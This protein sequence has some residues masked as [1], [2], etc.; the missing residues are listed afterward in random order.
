[1]KDNF[2]LK[3]NQ[4]EVFDELTDEEAGRLIKGIFSY[5]STGESNL[6]GSL[7]AVFIPIKNDIDRNEE[8]Y[9]RIVER[10]RENGK[11]GG[12]PKKDNDLEETQKNQSVILET[13]EN[14]KKPDTR[15]ISYITNHISNINNHNSNNNL[16]IIKEI[17]NYLNLK[18]N[19]SYKYT[20][21]ATQQKINARLNEGYILDDFIDV[22]D[23]K[24]NEWIGTE[25]ERYMN[26]DTLFGTKF[27][28]YLNQKTTKGRKTLKD[29]PMS[30]LDKAIESQKQRSG[31]S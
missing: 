31:I 4:Q 24:Y 30:V 9:Q 10:N 27:E 1:M 3:K 7:K 14:P 8:K 11:L 28:K 18:T 6:K 17:I 20:T 15:H 21:K 2:L 19:S 22:I 5:V 26:P 16:N 25:F 29:I 23:K 13:Q 12:R